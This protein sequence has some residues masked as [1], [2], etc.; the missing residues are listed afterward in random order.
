MVSMIGV[1]R[2]LLQSEGGGVTDC[3]SKDGIVFFYQEIEDVAG[4][5]YRVVV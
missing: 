5:G 3:E 4:E 1:M 2:D